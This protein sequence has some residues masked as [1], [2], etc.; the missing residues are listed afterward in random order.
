MNVVVNVCLKDEFIISYVVLMFFQ[1]LTKYI[2][3]KISLENYN[4]IDKII[5]ENKCTFNY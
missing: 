2:T 4:T 5:L 3:F 1:F